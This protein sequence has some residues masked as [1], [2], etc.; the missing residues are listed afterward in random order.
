MSPRLSDRHFHLHP[1]PHRTT[2]HPLTDIVSHV[3]DFHCRAYASSQK[4][5]SDHGDIGR[6]APNELSIPHN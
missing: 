5:K 3:G 4:Q 6:N 1:H 2:S